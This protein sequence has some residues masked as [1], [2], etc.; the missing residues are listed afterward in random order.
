MHMHGE[1]GA[2]ECPMM[3]KGDVPEPK[4]EEKKP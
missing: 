1:K 4:P 3:K 2:M